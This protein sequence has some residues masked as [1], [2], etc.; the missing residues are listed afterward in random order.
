MDPFWVELIRFF[1]F[2]DRD[3]SALL[4]YSFLLDLSYIWV[5]KL[6]SAF[7]LSGIRDTSCN[8]DLRFSGSMTEDL[9]SKP[10]DTINDWF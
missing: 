2:R 3:R 6:L 4:S 8:T 7:Y 1:L 9:F 5:Y 10:S